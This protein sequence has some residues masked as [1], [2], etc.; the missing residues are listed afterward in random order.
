[1]KNFK[2]S[3]LEG[4]ISLLGVILLARYLYKK[5]VLDDKK[6]SKAKK[7]LNNK[8]TPNKD[9]SGGKIV[10]EN[11]NEDRDKQYL[12]DIV[13]S[14][15]NTNEV[16]Y[17]LVKKFIGTR[18]FKSSED[19]LKE[20]IISIY[21]YS[22]SYD[23]CN[24]LLLNAPRSTND[25]EIFLKENN[26]FEEYKKIEIGKKSKNRKNKVQKNKNKFTIYV[27]R[28]KEDEELELDYA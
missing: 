1:M 18:S 14:D 22:D 23:R 4:V 11:D 25:L 6:E 3:D 24:E 16:V 26:L 17:N 15:S 8:K 12:R 10:K 13:N 19:L 27:K 7:G 9:T 2:I 28:Y 5:M 20:I 21:H